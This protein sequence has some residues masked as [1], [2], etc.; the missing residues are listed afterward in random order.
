MSQKP[1]MES[2]SE[3]QALKEYG[4]DEF[5]EYNSD[6]NDDCYANSI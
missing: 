6:E 3:V 1:P 2:P 4:E 5:E